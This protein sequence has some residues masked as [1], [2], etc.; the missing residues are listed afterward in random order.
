[1]YNVNFKRNF[2]C[3]SWWYKLAHAQ[4]PCGSQSADNKSEMPY[5]RLSYITIVH[6][7]VNRP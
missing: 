3:D 6:V 2:N 5:Y 7:Y 1:M 4:L